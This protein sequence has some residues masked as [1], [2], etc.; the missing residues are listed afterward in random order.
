MNKTE[1]FTFAMFNVQNSSD[2][3]RLSNIKPK[4][5][6]YKDKVI[7]SMSFVPALV[8]MENAFILAA[9]LVYWHKLKHNNVYRYVAS[10]LAANI[11]SSAFGFYHFLNYYHGFEPHQPNQWWAFRKGDPL[12][13]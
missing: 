7:L 3:F 6:P 12:F 5:E 1:T 2:D 13:D 10:C 4:C 8:V 11:V 9:M